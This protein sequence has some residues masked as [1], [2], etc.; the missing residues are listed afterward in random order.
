MPA[1]ATHL[2]HIHLVNAALFE[3]EEEDALRHAHLG[4]D[5]EDDVSVASQEPHQVAQHHEAGVLSVIKT[6]SWK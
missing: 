1:P 2:Q 5:V 4:H 3:E 6:R